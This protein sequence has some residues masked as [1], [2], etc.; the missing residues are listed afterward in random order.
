[1]IF[2]FLFLQPSTAHLEL[3][4]A[5]RKIVHIV[6]MLAQTSGFEYTESLMVASKSADSEIFLQLEWENRDLNSIMRNLANASNKVL[7]GKADYVDFTIELGTVLDYILTY[8]PLINTARDSTQEDLKSMREQCANFDVELD[9][10]RSEKAEIFSQLERD[11]EQAES[12]RPQSINGKLLLTYGAL[13]F[14]VH[15]IIP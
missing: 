1:M 3:A 7:Q 2:Y 15:I 8:R 11:V 6:E 5:V 9:R 4:I 12:V 14:Q 13:Q 10:L